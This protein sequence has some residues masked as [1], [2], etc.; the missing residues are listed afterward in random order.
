MKFGVCALAI[1]FF[2]RIVTLNDRVRLADDPDQLWTV[3]AE[4]NDGDRRAFDLEHETL[5]KRTVT[6]ADFATDDQLAKGQR[7][8]QPGLKSIVARADSTWAILAL[9]VFAPVPFIIAW[10]LRLLLS[11]QTIALTYRDAML[12]TFAGNFFNFTLP[13]T[14][15]G[16]IYKAFHI[17]KKTHKRAE[18]VTIVFLDRVFGLV[19]FLII[20]AVTVF[21][22]R[23][24]R[25]VGDFGTIVG[26]LLLA[27]VVGGL[28][29]SSKTVRQWVRYDNLL[30]RL[31]LS[32]KIRR[33]DQTAFN[34]RNHAGKALTALIGTAISHFCFV[35]AVYCLARCFGIE[36]T[37]T[38]TQ[39]GLYLAT[40]I[41]TVV[42][43]LVAAIPISIQGFGQ[44]EAVFYKIMVEGGWCQNSAMIVLTISARLIQVFW[45]LPGII[46]PWLGLERPDLSAADEEAMLDPT[47]E[48]D[49][50]VFDDGAA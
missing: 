3:V 28:A 40:L 15:G 9:A 50:R 25:I 49:E 34:L 4:S 45:S 17:A 27:L 31:P 39:S 5:G 48:F 42:G 38:Q 41:S 7:A 44:L 8:I 37:G 12:L 21:A 18:G 16:D 43:S 2:A 19:S 36:P 32:D 22:A 26:Y 46:A 23:H 10:R 29:F 13:G 35:T 6:S 47:S 1:W 30:A 33:I 24:T 14:T 20:A 11:T